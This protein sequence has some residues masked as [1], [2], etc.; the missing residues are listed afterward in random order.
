MPI[1]VDDGEG[2]GVVII[3][4]PAATTGCEAARPAADT[5]TTAR[6]K[7]DKR[8]RM[9]GPFKRGDGVPI[10]FSGVYARGVKRMCRPWGHALGT[11]HSSWPHGSPR[12]STSS[13]AWLMP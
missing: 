12:S 9:R 10:A 1:M 13:V 4:P 6:V 7:A 3:P 2:V 5:A 11:T 8:S